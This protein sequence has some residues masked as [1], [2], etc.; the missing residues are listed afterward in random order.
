M[1]KYKV[2]ISGKNPDYFLKKVIS[3]KINIYDICKN[4]NELI[5]VVDKDGF[6]KLNKLKTSY[7]LELICIYGKVK[8][9]EIINKYFFFILFFL[10]GILL[11][12]F[13]S[14]LILN[15]EVNHSNS[16]IREKVI[17]EL[18]K[19]NI[20][21]Y[22]FKVSFLKRE[23][24]V[25]KIL[26]EN[27]DLFEWI[28]IEEVGCKY[29]VNVERRKLNKKEEVC[30]NRNIVAKKNAFI[31]SIT[32]TSGEVRKKKND[33]VLSGDVIVSGVIYNKEDVVS[34]KCATG[35][36]YGEV[37]Y[38]V[39]VF[40]PVNYYEE[41]L[42]GRSKISL[43][44]K[45]FNKEYLLLNSYINYRKKNIINFDSSLLPISFGISRYLETNVVDY[46]YT[47]DNCSD[48][49]L[50]I[51]DKKIRDKLKDGEE[52]LTKKV[53]KKEVNNSKIRVEVFLKVKEDITSYQEI[54]N[55]N[56]Q[57]GG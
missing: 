14:K 44:F 39:D 7:K 4:Y 50:K 43:D 34:Y 20:S 42:T 27:K 17:N 12:I 26:D 37:W 31:M 55:I 35:K 38:K 53:L 54:N 48:E 51:A 16:Y 13:F 6:K 33:Y 47:L 29:V 9:I 15:I 10:M 41:N 11:N 1:D 3:N 46:K 28:E 56:S 45:F 57:D 25:N 8:F 24:I 49:A 22:K 18:K 2:L 19:N 52:I 30:V 21:K 40:L 23:E 36:I 32:A 5:I